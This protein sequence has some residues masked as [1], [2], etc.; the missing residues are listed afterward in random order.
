MLLCLYEQVAGYVLGVRFGP[1]MGAGCYLG[2][3]LQ[4]IRVRFPEGHLGGRGRSN[5]ESS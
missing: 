4:R 1:V 3:Y 2:G 5:L